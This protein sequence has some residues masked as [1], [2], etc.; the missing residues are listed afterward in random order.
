MLIIINILTA[1]NA[2]I[3]LTHS[4]FVIEDKL[5]LVNNFTSNA[6]LTRLL[7]FVYL[8]N[9]LFVNLVKAYGI[10]GEFDLLFSDIYIWC[11]NCPWAR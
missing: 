2:D 1:F 6:F 7:R 3:S 5:N 8:S 4:K 10:R 9:Q 11:G